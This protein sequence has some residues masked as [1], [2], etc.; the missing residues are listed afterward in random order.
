M[1]ATPIINRQL[2]KPFLLMSCYEVAFDN[3]LSLVHDLETSERKFNNNGRAKIEWQ[4]SVRAK[5]IQDKIKKCSEYLREL[6]AKIH[7][8]IVNHNQPLKKVA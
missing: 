5:E 1:K 2:T 8:Y 7:T 3:Y 6:D 4:E